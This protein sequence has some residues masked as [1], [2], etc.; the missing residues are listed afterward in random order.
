[1]Y[2]ELLQLI[3]KNQITQFKK[4]QKWSASLANREMQIKTTRYHFTP[5]KMARIKT[6]TSAEVVEKL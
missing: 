3:N 6:M 5:T 2:K 4:G 1:M